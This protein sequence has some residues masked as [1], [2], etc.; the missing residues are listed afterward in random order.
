MPQVEGAEEPQLLLRRDVRPEQQCGAQTLQNLGGEETGGADGGCGAKRSPRLS[1][2]SEDSQQDQKDLL[3]LREADGK[4]ARLPRRVGSSPCG[5]TLLCCS[6]Q[7]PSRNHRAYRLTVAK[8]GPPYIPFM[9]LLLK[10]DGS[11]LQVGFGIAPRSPP[12]SGLSQD[13][14]FINEG[15]PNYTEKLVNFEKMVSIPIRTLPDPRPIRAR[16]IS[17]FLQRMMAR[18]VKVVRACRSQPYSE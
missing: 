6:F 11:L 17:A 14:T 9:P 10:G 12:F 16:L 13:M 8:L 7:D 2:V 3:R 5:V 4:T 15:N 18:T 1:S